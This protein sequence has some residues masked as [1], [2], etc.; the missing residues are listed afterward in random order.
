MITLLEEIK[1][2]LVRWE[3]LEFISIHTGVS[4]ENIRKA[5]NLK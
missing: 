1:E 3:S 5:F 4:Q 2:R